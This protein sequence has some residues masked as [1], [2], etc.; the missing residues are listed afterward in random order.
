MNLDEAGANTGWVA[1]IPSMQ[2]V[3]TFLTF[4]AKTIVVAL[5]RAKKKNAVK[6]GRKKPPPPQ[7]ISLCFVDGEEYRFRQVRATYKD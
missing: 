1:F 7:E 4:E 3:T 6:D 2:V 5:S